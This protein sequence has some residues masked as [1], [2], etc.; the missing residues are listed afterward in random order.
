MSRDVVVEGR[1]TRAQ[2]VE[3]VAGEIRMRTVPRDCET[4]ADVEA[5]AI[6]MAT[7][8]VDEAI[9]Q[10]RDGVIE[11]TLTVVPGN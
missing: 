2:M 8:C 11:A 1:F 3:R 4:A 10:A 6:A 7:K 5:F 9:A